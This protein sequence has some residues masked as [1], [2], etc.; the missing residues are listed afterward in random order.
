MADGI[1]TQ[2]LKVFAGHHAS[3]CPLLCQV[4]LAEPDFASPEEFLIKCGTW[5]TL[6]REER[7]LRRLAAER[8][9]QDHLLV[10][11]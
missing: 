9:S 5:L 4:L 1:S 3:E 7:A 10:R 2:P 6:L 11:K 8:P